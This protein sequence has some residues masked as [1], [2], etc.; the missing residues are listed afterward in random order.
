[1]RHP[2]STYNEKMKNVNYA[3][4][5]RV[6]WHKNRSKLASQRPQ[7]SWR[8]GILVRDDR[9]CTAKLIRR[10]VRLKYALCHDGDGVFVCI[11]HD[12]RNTGNASIQAA[13]GPAVMMKA[14]LNRV[15][16]GHPSSSYAA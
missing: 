4:E 8:R 10:V 11:G 3:N 16:Q 1:V 5:I 2:C 15:R 7:S 12:T 14:E 13:A 9:S 6:V